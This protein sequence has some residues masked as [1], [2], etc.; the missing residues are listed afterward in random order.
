MIELD[1]DCVIYPEKYDLNPFGGYDIALIGVDQNR[2]P[3]ELFS[4]KPINY[5]PKI[6]EFDFSSQ[7]IVC[8]YPQNTE[9]HDGNP[10]KYMLGYASDITKNRVIC[11]KDI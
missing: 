1:P 11:Y 6:R 8:G 5:N 3:K 10:F 7:I 2:V 9:Y 4:L